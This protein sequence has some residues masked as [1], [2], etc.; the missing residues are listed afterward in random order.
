MPSLLGKID[1][2]IKKLVDAAALSMTVSDDAGG[3]RILPLNASIG[4]D[5]DIQTLPIL[6]IHSSRGEEKP[7]GSGNYMVTVTMDLQT[8]ADDTTEEQHENLCEMLFN[9]ISTDD[10]GAQISNQD[11]DLTVYDP[12]INRRISSRVTDDSWISSLEFECYAC[13]TRLL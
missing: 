7:V 13:R 4:L 9:M 2:G 3:T 12:T 1:E 8:N 5:N 10:I 6:K 11:E